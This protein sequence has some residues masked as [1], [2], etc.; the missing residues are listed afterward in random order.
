[1][2]LRELLLLCGLHRRKVDRFAGILLDSEMI[3]SLR[4]EQ[5]SKVHTLFVRTAAARRRNARVDTR[6]KSG[7]TAETVPPIGPHAVC[8]P[9]VHT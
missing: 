5:G 2:W 7:I 1:M 8:A 6:N 3:L 9:V 4:D